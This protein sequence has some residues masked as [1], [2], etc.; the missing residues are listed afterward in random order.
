MLHE[1]QKTGCFSGLPGGMQYKIFL[2]VD[3]GKNFRQIEA[4]ERWNTVMI[5]AFHRPSGVEKT[6]QAFD[7]SV[8]A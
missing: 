8:I 6:F 7:P 4:L 5:V 1:R 3:Q 2:L